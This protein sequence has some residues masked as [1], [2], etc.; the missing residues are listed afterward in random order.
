M[1]PELN[2]IAANEHIADLRRAAERDRFARSAKHES[3][4][5]RVFARLRVRDRP[6]GRPEPARRSDAGS[7]TG[8]TDPAAAEA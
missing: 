2:Y 5:S 3:Y 8:A 7:A 1:H 4:L 6:L